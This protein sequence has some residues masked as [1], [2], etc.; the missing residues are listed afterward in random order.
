MII[1]LIYPTALGER[2]HFAIRKGNKTVDT[3]IIMKFVR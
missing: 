3:K 1:D 2:P